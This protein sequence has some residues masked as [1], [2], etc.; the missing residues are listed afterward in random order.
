MV[1]PTAR[2]FL[3][4]RDSSVRSCIHCNKSPSGSPVPA[5]VIVPR[6]DVQANYHS[7]VTHVGRGESG[8]AALW[9]SG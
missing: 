3:M 7:R 5:P 8:P 4:T 9:Y 1:T 2:A 6:P